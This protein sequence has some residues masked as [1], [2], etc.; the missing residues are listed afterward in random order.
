MRE[1]MARAFKG[2]GQRWANSGAKGRYSIVHAVFMP[3]QGE[4]QEGEGV[5]PGGSRSEYHSRFGSE[6]TDRP[7]TDIPVRHRNIG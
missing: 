6:P 5:S 7:E 1:F 4:M 2:L 3:T